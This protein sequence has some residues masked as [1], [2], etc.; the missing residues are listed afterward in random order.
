[1]HRDSPET[2]RKLCISKKFPH[3][4]KSKISVFS[5]VE[6][7]NGSRKYKTNLEQNN[8]SHHEIFCLF[9]IIR[10]LLLFLYVK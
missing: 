7:R 6:T 4:K 8:F 2:L 1:M 5:T 9:V 10:L 3:R